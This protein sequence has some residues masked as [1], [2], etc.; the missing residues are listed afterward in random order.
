[1]KQRLTQWVERAWYGDKAAPIFLRPL[2]LI[3]ARIARRRLQQFRDTQQ[4]PPVPLLVVGNITVGGTGKT[5]LVVALCQAAKQRGLSV[6]IVSRGYGANPPQ[7]PWHVTAEQDAA[8][9]GDEPL[10]LAQKTGVPIF[11][12]PQRKQALEAALQVN[13]DLIISDDGLQHYALPRSVEL[14]VLDG[15]RMLGNGWCLP[16]GPLREPAERLHKVDWVIINGGKQQQ[17]QW[18]NTINMQLVAGEYW[19][20]N[21][22]ERLSAEQFTARYQTVEAVAAIGH[23]ER[24]FRT[25]EQQGLNV[26]PH[27]FPDHHAFRPEDLAIA[28]N[29]PIVMTEKDA[30]KCAQWLDSRGWVFG[31]E[32]RLPD[33]FYQ[34]LF[35]R[36][37]A[38]TTP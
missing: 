7:Y 35:Q 6:A 38:G 22:G 33:E 9:A 20:P 31:V 16:A 25:L 8:Q 10:M 17:Y 36:L 27:A 30:V 28:G 1:M 4:T 13:P 11:I 14:A 15:E 5:P 2:S 32:A 29:H 21:T 19:Q 23:P 26:S 37:L 24:F 3:V 12:D 34:Q 18:P